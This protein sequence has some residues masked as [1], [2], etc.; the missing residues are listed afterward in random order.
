M[1]VLSYCTFKEELPQP[2]RQTNLATEV[3]IQDIHACHLV[4]FSA[5]QLLSSLVLPKVKR[6]LAETHFQII[7]T[8]PWL[9]V[10]SWFQ[11]HKHLIRFSS[12]WEVP[13]HVAAVRR[14]CKCCL[15]W[16]SK[17][18]V[19]DVNGSQWPVLFNGYAGYACVLCHRMTMTYSW[20]A[21]SK[22]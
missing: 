8:A 2:W 14:W 11:A 3:N 12:L 1:W 10:A 20:S 17:S 4:K 18:R 13:L 5:W 6:N 9:P 16:T 7:Q 22:F 15:C 19:H 21:N